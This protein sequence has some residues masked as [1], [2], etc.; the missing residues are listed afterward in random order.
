MRIISCASYYGSGSSAITDL[1]S[2]YNNIY[3]FTDEEF[4]FVQDPDGISDLEYN[5]VQNFNRHNSGR[6]IKRYKKLVDFYSGNIFSHKYE[7]YFHGKWKKMSYQ[8]ISDLVDFSYKGSWMYDYLDRGVTFY[9]LTHL[10]T[11]LLHATIWRKQPERFLNLLSNE[12][13]YCSH[14]TENKF[15]SLTRK[16]IDELFGSASKGYSNVV[17]DQIVP[18][19]NLSR[20]LRYFNDIDVIIVDR[21]PRDIYCLEKYVWKDGMIPTDVETFCKWFKYTR[22]QRE[23]EVKQNKHVY[24]VQFEDLIFHYEDTVKQVEKS[25]SLNSEDH[26]EVRKYFNPKESIKNTQ[27]WKKFNCD[28]TE[29]KYIEQELADYLYHF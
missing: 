16:Y 20:Y 9:Y 4:R 12:I 15:L 22:Y 3:S 5:L 1:L 29:I 10:P 21:D 19:T 24:F 11:K 8:Y 17:I 2:E 25:L 13:T 27:T 26:N 18:S 14:P 7:K 6:A 23:N 28:A